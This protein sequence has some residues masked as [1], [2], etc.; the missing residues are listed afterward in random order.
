MATCTRCVRP[1]PRFCII[2]EVTPPATSRSKSV[3]MCAHA[4]GHPASHHGAATAPLA[5]TCRSRQS[6]QP[7]SLL[8]LPQADSGELWR[9]RHIPY[10][11]MFVCRLRE[12]CAGPHRGAGGRDP[13]APQSGESAALSACTCIPT[14]G[15]D[16]DSYG[17]RTGCRLFG[18]LHSPASLVEICHDFVVRTLA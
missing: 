6:P 3:C 9:N 10:R 14:V 13:S 2:C 18:P 1:L 7:G 15:L 17:S 16:L 12:Y 4:P 5:R 8:A 11:V